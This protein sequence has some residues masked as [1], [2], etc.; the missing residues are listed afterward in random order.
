MLVDSEAI[1]LVIIELALVHDKS[2]LSAGMIECTL[3]VGFPVSPLPNIF[4]SVHPILGSSAML[5]VAYY[6]MIRL[7]C[8]E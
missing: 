8:P 2:P 5:G 4:G 7:S 3:A 1:G 6:Q